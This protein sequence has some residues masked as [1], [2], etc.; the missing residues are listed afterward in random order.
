MIVILKILK[1]NF[2]DL[3]AAG[4]FILQFQSADK[5]ARAEA[6]LMPDL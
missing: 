3:I 6:L 1:E 4:Q 5:A 2:T